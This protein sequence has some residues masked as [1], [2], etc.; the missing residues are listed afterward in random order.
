M[1]A[2]RRLFMPADSLQIRDPLSNDKRKGNIMNPP[3]YAEIGGATSANVRGFEAAGQGMT[4]QTPES[5]Q[6]RVPVK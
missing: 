2:Q 6:R 5:T 3:R 4:I 1:P